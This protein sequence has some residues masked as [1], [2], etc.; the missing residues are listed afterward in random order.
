[1]AGTRYDHYYDKRIKNSVLIVEN[2]YGRTHHWTDIDR[3]DSA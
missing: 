3:L 2:G 1:M